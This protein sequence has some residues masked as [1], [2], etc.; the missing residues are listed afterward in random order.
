MHI[1]LATMA[2]I[3]ELSVLIPLAARALSVGFYSE[4]ETEAAIRYIF[5]V[6]TQLVSD[7]TYLVVEEAGVILGCGGWSRRRSLYGGDQKKTGPDPLLDPAADAA[8]IRAF[9]VHPDFAR[10]GIG[11]MLMHACIAAARAAGFTRLELVATLPGEP[12]YRRFGFAELER[13]EDTLP[14]STRVPVVRMGAVL[15]SLNIPSAQP[16]APS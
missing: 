15:A 13:F 14:D 1:R 7:R 8:R 16:G 3:P 2:D 12:L 6:D 11:S 10:R 5:G 4:R 9:F